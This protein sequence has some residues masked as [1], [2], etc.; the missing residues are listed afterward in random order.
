VTQN[1]NASAC[2]LK[3]AVEHAS[4]SAVGSQLHAR[5]AAAENNFHLSN[6]QAS[7]TTKAT[8]S[9]N[10]FIP[11]PNSTSKVQDIKQ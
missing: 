5:D 6:P 1:R 10:K 9:Y 4:V 7:T 3:Q 8:N 11:F 2:L